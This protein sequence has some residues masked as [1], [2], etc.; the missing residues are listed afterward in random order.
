MSNVVS[1]LKSPEFNN[2]AQNKSWLQSITLE[3]DGKWAI[4]TASSWQLLK[5]V[6]SHL[7]NIFSSCKAN[8][9]A[10]ALKA[11]YISDAQEMNL[12]EVTDQFLQLGRL[13]GCQ[14]ELP[15]SAPVISEAE[16]GRDNE[17]EEAQL[18]SRALFE[19]KQTAAQENQRHFIN[20]ALDYLAHLYQ[21]SKSCKKNN[22][23]T[24]DRIFNLK[25]KVSTWLNYVREKVEQTKY[26]SFRP[27]YDEF[28]QRLETLNSKY[29][30][31]VSKFRSQPD[32]SGMVM[33]DPCE[34]ILQESD[35]ATQQKE[36][37]QNEKS[38]LSN[39]EA[40]FDQLNL[41]IAHFI[42]ENA[43]TLI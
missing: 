40:Q 38:E 32:F 39:L 30:E 29:S 16:K 18:E 21:K 10:Q 9:R 37:R 17:L 12:S 6:F 5:D 31:L 22:N 1:F 33:E 2:Y 3:Q 7:T 19:S 41:D 34:A 15:P 11:Q 24:H 27:K 36:M 28:V 35:I 20:D 23:E 14:M 42:H 13:I 4:K 43:T 25:S 8:E 26:Q